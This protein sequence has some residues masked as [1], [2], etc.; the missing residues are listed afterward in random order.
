MAFEKA[1]GAMMERDD[2]NIVTAMLDKG[3]LSA[4]CGVGEYIYV[5]ISPDPPSRLSH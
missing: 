3:E 2:W 1:Y 4:G 5:Y